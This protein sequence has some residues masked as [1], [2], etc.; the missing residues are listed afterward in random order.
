MNFSRR[1]WQG[2]MLAAAAMLLPWGCATGPYYYP[3]PPGPPVPPRLYPGDLRVT[4]LDMSPDPI[5]TGERPRFSVTIYN[6]SPVS[7]QVRVLISD[8]DELV[9]EARGVWI[10]P[11]VNRVEFPRSSYRFH[12]A[13]HCF[14]VEL[15]IEGTRHPLDLARRFCARRTAGGWTLAP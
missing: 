9:A 13:D 4:D 7:G 6:R 11:G 12:R 8:R 1:A 15:D 14:M 10:R 2:G 5:V 3:P